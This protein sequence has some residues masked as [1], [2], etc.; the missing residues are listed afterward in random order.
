VN[1][2]EDTPTSDPTPDLADVRRRLALVTGEPY[3]L[4]DLADALLLLLPPT[5]A[6]DRHTVDDFP[7]NTTIDEVPGWVLGDHT[8]RVAP[9]MRY[10]VHWVQGNT[11]WHTTPE[12]ATEF[13]AVLLSAAARARRA[14][15]P[16]EGA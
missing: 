8:I 1:F 4:V 9:G 3:Q 7:P 15:A 6:E 12:E 14:I 10:S 13:A 16:K 5:P 11:K 2:T